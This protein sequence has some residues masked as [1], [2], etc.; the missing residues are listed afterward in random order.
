MFRVLSDNF[1]S[2]SQIFTAFDPICLKTNEGSVPGTTEGS[3]LL[4]ESEPAPIQQAAK[5]NPGLAMFL[6]PVC[7]SCLFFAAETISSH[8]DVHSAASSAGTFQASS[9]ARL[10]QPV[11]AWRDVP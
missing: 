6:V 8:L 11:V 9:L 5:T 4:Q 2:R 10:V 7:F 1:A 3:S